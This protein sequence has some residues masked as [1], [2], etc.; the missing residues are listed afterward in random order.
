[1]YVPVPADYDCNYSSTG[2]CW[3]RLNVT[4]P[5]STVTDITTWSASIEGDPVRIVE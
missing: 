1:M 2:G 5:G 4:F 3:F